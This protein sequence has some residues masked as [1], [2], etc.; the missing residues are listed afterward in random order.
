MRRFTLILAALLIASLG[1]FVA[2]HVHIHGFNGSTNAYAFGGDCGNPLDSEGVVYDD[3]QARSGGWAAGPPGGPVVWVDTDI[4][5]WRYSDPG[6][7]HCFYGY[8]NSTWEEQGVAGYADV[9]SSLRIWV[10]GNFAGEAQHG[11]PNT[12]MTDEFWI[13]WNG[14]SGSAYAIWVNDAY[15]NGQTVTFLDYSYLGYQCGHQVDN[16]KSSIWKSNWSSGL[17]ITGPSCGMTPCPGY[18]HETDLH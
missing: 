11:V 16:V 2:S 4:H 14:V 5:A 1:M 13:N 7:H 10:C 6:T 8:R 3:G 12:W 17:Y 15:P 9:V 18:L